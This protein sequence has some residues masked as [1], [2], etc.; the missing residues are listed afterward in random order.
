M[1]YT[2]LQW[3]CKWLSRRN[4]INAFIMRRLAVLQEGLRYYIVLPAVISL[5]KSALSC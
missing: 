1:E 5:Q 3:P 4:E 2:Y